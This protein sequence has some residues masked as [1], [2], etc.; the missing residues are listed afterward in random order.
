LNLQVEFRQNELHHVYTPS[1]QHHPA[2]LLRWLIA[3]RASSVPESL[4]LLVE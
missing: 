4:L 3:A 2:S 1:D